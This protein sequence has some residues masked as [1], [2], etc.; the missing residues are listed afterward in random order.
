MSIPRPQ[1][2]TDNRWQDRAACRDVGDP[3][4]F[5][6]PTGPPS[7]RVFQLCDPCPVR[8]ECLD[9]ALSAESP[10]RANVGN[11][12][13]IWGGTTPQERASIAREQSRGQQHCGGVDEVA[14]DR[15]MGGQRTRLTI[16]ERREAV[17]RLHGYGL[18]DQD[19]ARRLHIS[20][21]TVLRIRQR[22]GLP[23]NYDSSRNITEET[24]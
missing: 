5:F 9:Y 15:A 21:R 20:D 3:E 7:Q 18:T 14:I 16:P 6:P 23:A 19:T 13:G 24:A 4:L 22:M 1:V 8:V 10:D 17:R 2:P 12:H 11:R